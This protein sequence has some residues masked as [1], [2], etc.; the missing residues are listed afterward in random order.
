MEYSVL[1]DVYLTI[2][3]VNLWRKHCMYQIRYD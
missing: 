2:Y 3:I 1:Y